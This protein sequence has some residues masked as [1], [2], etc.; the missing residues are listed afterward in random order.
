MK[1]TIQITEEDINEMHDKHVEICTINY[2]QTN[3]LLMCLQLVECAA[4][5]IHSTIIEGLFELLPKMYLLL[6]HPL[7]AVSK[8]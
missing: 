6:K 8:F 7:K 2:E 5:S 4:P 3:E 1:D